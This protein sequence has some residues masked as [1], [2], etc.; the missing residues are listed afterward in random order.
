MLGRAISS[1]TI[2]IA[3]ASTVTLIDTSS[4]EISARK[5]YAMGFIHGV[6]STSLITTEARLCN[7]LYDTWYCTYG[8]FCLSM[9]LPNVQCFSLNLAFYFPQTYCRDLSDSRFQEQPNYST[10]NLRLGNY[11]TKGNYLID[12]VTWDV[13]YHTPPIVTKRIIPIRNKEPMAFSILFCD[14][15]TWCDFTINLM[16]GKYNWKIREREKWF[17]SWKKN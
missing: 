14:C 13:S 8:Y 11:H 2:S 15:Q 3:F 7:V 16:L 5:S 10:S 6:A 4:G 1:V 9:D 17:I 12:S